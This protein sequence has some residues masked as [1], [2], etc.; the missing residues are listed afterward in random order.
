MPD[1]GTLLEYRDY[2]VALDEIE[3]KS[4]PLELVVV[5][6]IDPAELES[7]FVLLPIGN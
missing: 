3:N 6:C 7:R 1:D 4:L 5:K 2:C